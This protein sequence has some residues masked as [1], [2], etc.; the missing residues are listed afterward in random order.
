ML[1][2]INAKLQKKNIEVVFSNE[3]KQFLL[4]KG[5]D[6]YY[7]ARPL[8]RILQKYVEDAIAEEILLKHNLATTDKLYK[9]LSYIDPVSEKIRFELSGSYPDIKEVT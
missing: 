6:Q 7:G 1:I 5:F 3:V 4:E 9:V 8:L 2:K